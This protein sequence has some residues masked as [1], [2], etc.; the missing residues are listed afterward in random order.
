MAVP[1][2]KRT[3]WCGLSVSVRRA[4]ETSPAFRVLHHHHAR[5]AAPRLTKF[6]YRVLPRAKALCSGLQE[7]RRLTRSLYLLT[8]MKTQLVVPRTPRSPHPRPGSAL[9]VRDCNPQVQILSADR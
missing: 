2:G 4:Q 7:I 1:F 3:I 6:I 8:G 9:C 5:P